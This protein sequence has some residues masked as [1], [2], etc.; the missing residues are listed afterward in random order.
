[1]KMAMRRAFSG[2]GWV[3]PKVLMKMLDSQRRG[4]IGQQKAS[5]E[6]IIVQQRCP[7][8]DSQ[9]CRIGSGG[10]ATAA[11]SAHLLW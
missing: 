10:D 7:A 1:M 6:A 4:F 9:M 3:M 8:H 2:V 5:F 11:I